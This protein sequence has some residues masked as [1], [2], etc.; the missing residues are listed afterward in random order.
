LALLAAFAFLGLAM[1][2]SVA[3]DEA[4]A[5]TVP[6]VPPP[7]VTIRTEVDV[8]EVPVVVRDGQHRAVAGLTRNDFEV[9]DTGVRQ[10]ITAFS[11]Q[12]FT[13][14]VDA[15]GVKK[16]AVV[17]A[18]PA[19]PQSEPRP[20]F[21]ALCFDDLNSDALALKPVKEAAQ[22][23]VKT[24]LAPGDRVA[25]VTVA[26]SQDS[27]FTADVPKL[28]EQIAKVTSHRRSADDSVQQCPRIRPYEAYLIANKLDNDLLQAKIGECSACWHHSPCPP[29]QVTSMSETIWQHAQNNSKNTLRV[30]ESLV[31]G[32][33]KLPGERMILLASAG[34]LTG[35]LEVDQDLLMAKALHAEVVI[36]TLDIK[37]L[38][39]VIPGGDASTSQGGWIPPSARVVEIKN[40]ERVV[41]APNDAMAVLASGTGGAFY[42]NNNDLALGFRRLGMVP[43][44]M[45]VLGFS[46]SGVAADGRFH[47]LKVRLAAGQRYSL[48]ARLGYAASSADAPV[49]GS[50]SSKLDSE[51]MASDTV[52]DLP[53]RFTWERW[54]GP[55]GI[56]MVAHLDLDRLHFEIRQGRRGQK[57]ALVGV[58]LDSRGG[59]VTGKRSEL[60]LNLTDATFAQLTKAGFTV[61]MT[62]EAPPGTYAVRGVVEDALEGKLTAASGAVEIKAPVEP[63][64]EALPPR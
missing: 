50:P 41:Q 3:P 59:F 16:P 48:Q 60:D 39:T 31:D 49:P 7:K 47:S 63:P 22:R 43:E 17:P 64:P 18:A 54:A 15:G 27:E 42:H 40:A 21:V 2:Q 11:E 61:S 35:N 37:G 45:Y 28:V 29:N 56:T 13:S 46:P 14:Q 55:P 53:V 44:T 23:F 20:R 8:V 10:T 58:L 32:M 62:L 51:A 26:Q 52:T 24:G 38:Y 6:Y 36:N 9:Y 25:V 5:R 33:A 30:M 19:A 4:H 1:A 34:F 12:H 57:L